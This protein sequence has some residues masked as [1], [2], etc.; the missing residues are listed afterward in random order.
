MSVFMLVF[1]GP[2]A[3]GSA[4]W[5]SLAS[6]RGITSTL[7][8]TSLSAAISLVITAHRQL[9]E[10]HGVDLTPSEYWPQFT[11][12]MEPS[13]HEGPILVVAEYSIEPDRLSEF[14]S[15]MG[16]LKTIRLR[17]GAF[18]WNLFKEAG[19]PHRF[20]ESFI[21]QSWGEYLRQRERFTVSDDGSIDIVQSCQ[22]DG[23]SVV[24]RH[25]IA[26]PVK[27]EK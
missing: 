8:I 16:R 2:F 15:A 3:I 13:I 14:V 12:E 25:F 22:E 19:A 17:D 10:P 4:L 7:V 18:R 11:G 6:W 9:S 23:Q 27:R 1:F 20:I 26:Q 24:I 21:V 5:G